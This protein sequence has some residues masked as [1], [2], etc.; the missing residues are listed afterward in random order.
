MRWACLW[1]MACTATEPP[2]TV[3]EAVDDPVEPVD[4]F[5]PVETLERV[6]LDR[7]RYPNAQCNDGTHGMYYQRKGRPGS[8]RWVIMLEGGGACSSP[9]ECERRQRNRPELMT[10][11]A[12]L[13]VDT[14]HR[15]GI[16]SVDEVHNPLFYDAHHI[17]ILYCSS[18]WWSGAR[19][20]VRE[21][22]GLHMRGHTIL[23][24][25]LDQLRDEG[26]EDATEILLVGAS[27]GG[28]G[29]EL[30]L[31][32][33]AQWFPDARVRGLQDAMWPSDPEPY[34]SPD[35]WQTLDVDAWIEERL[36]WNTPVYDDCYARLADPR[37][38]ERHFFA[39]QIDTPLFVRTAQRDP[40][41]LDGVQEAAERAGHVFD[42]DI[43]V[44]QLLRSLRSLEARHGVFAPD[45]DTHVTVHEDAF[46]HER[47]DGVSAMELVQGWWTDDVLDIRVIE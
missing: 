1:V 41:W 8:T 43:A 32:Q 46:F 2:E 4:A 9:E 39:H 16:L 12:A 40:I 27:A 34:R 13:H 6:D 19:G 18:D 35:H 29:V 11:D 47:V 17:E 45:V 21:L 31:D 30:N 24:A 10:S 33:V 26:I 37:C 5:V 15:S 14:L 44:E 36:A 38:F 20:N 42:A 25:T 28:I 23:R 3:D 7:D 22:G